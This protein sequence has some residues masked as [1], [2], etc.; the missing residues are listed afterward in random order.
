MGS[1][2]ATSRFQTAV[3]MNGSLVREGLWSWVWA[4]EDYVKVAK[5]TTMA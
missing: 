3:I 4:I 1:S 2:L 5:V